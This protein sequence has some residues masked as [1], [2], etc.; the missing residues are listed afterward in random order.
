MLV[1]L[2]PLCLAAH[3]QTRRDKSQHT[4]TEYDELLT[5]EVLA[6]RV[7]PCQEWTSDKEI[8]KEG[9]G[10]SKKVLE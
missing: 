10:V 6:V 2:E 1:D 9:L 7:E 3:H 5:L 8:V 4:L